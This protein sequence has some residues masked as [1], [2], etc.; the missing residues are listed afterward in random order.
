VRPTAE[1]AGT[2]GDL[3]ERLATGPTRAYAAT[4]AAIRAWSRRSL[5]DQMELEAGLQQTLVTTDDW[6]EGRAAFRER[7]EP[8]YTGS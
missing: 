7:R 4:K 2:A 5:A 3:A 1:V 6:A 8:R